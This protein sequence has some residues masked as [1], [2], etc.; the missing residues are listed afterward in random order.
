MW[1]SWLYKRQVQKLAS[2]QTEVY[3][4]TFYIH[5]SLN[6]SSNNREV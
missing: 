3:M 5:E 2:K 6:I 4:N 1:Y